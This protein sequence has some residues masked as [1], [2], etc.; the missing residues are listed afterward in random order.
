MKTTINKPDGN[1]NSQTYKKLISDL[2]ED[3]R[4]GCYFKYLY[5]YSLNTPEHSIVDAV[6]IV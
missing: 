5:L 3:S 1:K 2:S 4:Q 6:R